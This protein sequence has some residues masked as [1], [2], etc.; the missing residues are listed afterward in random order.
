MK[1]NISLLVAVVLGIGLLTLFSSLNGRVAANDELICTIKTEVTE[2]PNGVTFTSICTGTQDSWATLKFGDGLEVDLMVA[3]S[4]EVEPTSHFYDYEVGGLRTYTASLHIDDTVF[5]ET[6][7]INDRLEPSVTMCSLAITQTALN[8]FEFQPECE[9]DHEWLEFNFGDGVYTM[10]PTDEP[11]VYPH[12]YAYTLQGVASYTVTIRLD[13]SLL[14][15][16]TVTIDDR[17]F[18]P[19]CTVFL[20]LTGRNF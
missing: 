17:D 18:V 4:G 13:D 6:V 9:S 5:T 19:V 15:T 20:P 8:S 16:D 14:L 12:S 7:E 1:R 2:A 11:N 3:E 10:F